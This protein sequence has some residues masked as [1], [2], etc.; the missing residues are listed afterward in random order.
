MDKNTLYRAAVKLSFDFSL[1]VIAY[2]EGLEIL[3]KFI[4]SEHLL[5]YGTAVG[6][7]IRE[8]KNAP[9]KSR[10]RY[11][12]ERAKEETGKVM[13]WL[14]LCEQ[15]DSYPDCSALVEKAEQLQTV[16]HAILEPE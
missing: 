13:Y 5:R 15:S 7:E 14:Q 2:I 10:Y 3:K 16:L 6:A 4:I 9:T 1:E 12:I 8:A 11:Q